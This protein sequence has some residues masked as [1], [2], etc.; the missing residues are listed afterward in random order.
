MRWTDIAAVA[1]LTLVPMVG[2]QAALTVV[3]DY[4]GQPAQPYY[5]P[6]IG[7]D[8]GNAATG[9]PRYQGPTTEAAMLPVESKRLSSGPVP[10]RGLQMPTTMRPFF[11]VGADSMSLSWLQQRRDRLHALHAVGL[12]VDV[13]TQQQLQQ[14][15]AAGD[16]LAMH[17]VDGDDIARRL[18]LSHYPVLITADG[19]QQ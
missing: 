18:D 14:L 10:G 12:I 2:A 13:D 7:A 11:L 6:M 5:A 16:G 1:A 17:P 19:V 15:R 3:A 8:D 9:N 4:G